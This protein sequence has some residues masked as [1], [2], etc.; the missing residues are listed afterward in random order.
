LWLAIK[1]ERKLGDRAAETSLVT[2]LSRRYPDSRE[3]SA[4]QRGMFND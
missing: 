3:F 1:I 2:Q 4:Y